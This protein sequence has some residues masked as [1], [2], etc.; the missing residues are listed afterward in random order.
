[1]GLLHSAQPRDKKPFFY[2]RSDGPTWGYWRVCIMEWG[3][4]STESV[5]STRL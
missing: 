3:F 4:R 5:R 2:R 1:M